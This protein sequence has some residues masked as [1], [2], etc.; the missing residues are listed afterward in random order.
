MFCLPL[1]ERGFCHGA[2]VTRDIACG[3]IAVGG[4]EELL[5]TGDIGA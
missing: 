2:K 3:E 4:G 5:E 1:L